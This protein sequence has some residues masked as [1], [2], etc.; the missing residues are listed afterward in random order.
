MILP[1]DK[2]IARK[3]QSSKDFL[4]KKDMIQQIEKLVMFLEVVSP[5]ENECGFSEME[6]SSFHR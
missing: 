5:T 1:Q 6:K 3:C 4:D 2:K